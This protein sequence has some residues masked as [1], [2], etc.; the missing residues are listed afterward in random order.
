MMPNGHQRALYAEHDE[1]LSLGIS[2]VAAKLA[3]ELPLIT[4]AM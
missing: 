1:R 3:R 2:L 4:A